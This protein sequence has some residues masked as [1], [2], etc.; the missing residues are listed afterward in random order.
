MAIQ[1]RTA[2]SS[3]EIGSSDLLRSFFDSIDVHLTKGIFGRK[4]PVVLGRFQ[5]GNLAYEELDKAKEE[6]EHIQKRLHK[7]PPGKVIWDKYDRSSK[8]PWGDD[9]SPEIT[10]LANYFVT[11]DGDDLFEIIHQAIATARQ[12][13]SGIT[14]A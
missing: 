4:Y 13:R 14:I 10:S 11:S 3:F 7:I 2:D 12:E 9:I 8:P 6:L 1:L 5:E